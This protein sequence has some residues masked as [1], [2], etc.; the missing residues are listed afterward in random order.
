MIPD[1]SRNF[2]HRLLG[3]A[4]WLRGGQRQSSTYLSVREINEPSR[5][6]LSVRGNISTLECDRELANCVD[7]VFLSIDDGHRSLVESPAIKEKP[8]KASERG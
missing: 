5:R 4:G 2:F 8:K 3:L 7:R 1:N 6:I